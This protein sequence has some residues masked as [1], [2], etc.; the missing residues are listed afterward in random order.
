M[1]QH[2]EVLAIVKEVNPTAEVV[3]WS[4]MFD[5]NHNAVEKYHLVNGPLTGSWE[6]LPKEVIVAN[7]NSG[8]AAASR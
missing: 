5:P 8:K 4:D 6:G 2:R 3:I 1:R 7:W